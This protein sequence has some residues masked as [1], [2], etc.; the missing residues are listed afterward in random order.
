VAQNHEFETLKQ[1]STNTAAIEH[2]YDY[3]AK[4]YDEDIRNWDYKAPKEA[5]SQLAPHLP[6]G[7]RVLDVGCGTGLVAEALLELCGCWIKGID[8]SEASLEIAER[9]SVYREL[10]RCNLQQLPLPLEKDSFDAAISIGVMTY[11]ADPA[12]L[13]ADLCRIVRSDGHILFTHRDD[14]WRKQGF[15]KL[16]K[17]IEARNLWKVLH[18]SEPRAYLPANE[19]FASDIKA[20]FA[21]SR[22][23]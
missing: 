6:N 9:R 2:Y 20:I 7:A 17:E 18:I 13:L 4:N 22:V 23:C 1:G 16:M 11:I 10:Q 8:I 21:F 5:A 19:D 3:W 12:T 14:N 15:N